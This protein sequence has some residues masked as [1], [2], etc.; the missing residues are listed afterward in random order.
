MPV[1]TEDEIHRWFERFRN[2]DR[3]GPDD[4]LGTLNHLTP[5]RRVAATR[6]VAHGRSVSLSWD[7]EMDPMEGQHIAP[8]RWMFRTGL[9]LDEPAPPAGPRSRDGLMGTASEFISMVFHGRTITHLDALS[10]VF[11]KGQ[12]YGGRPSWQVTDRDGASVHDVR[13]ARDGIQARGVLLDIARVR[14]VAAL[15]PGEPVYPADL[16]AAERAQGVRVA[17]GDVLLMRTGDGAR[18]RSGHWQPSKDGQPGFHAACIPWLYQRDVAAIGSD[19]PQDVNP[20][21]YP[22]IFLPVHSV[23][24]VAMGMWL[25]DNCQL[26]DLSSACAELGKWDFLF[27]LGALRLAGVTGGPVNPIALL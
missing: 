11:W 13:S 26:E 24:I 3:W 21:S 14:G 4:L 1:P 2:W 19:G 18:R 16:D 17:P 25:V 27:S 9:G 15:E 20:S 23:C 22:G 10:H 12:M 8:Q 6:C 7:I 5:E